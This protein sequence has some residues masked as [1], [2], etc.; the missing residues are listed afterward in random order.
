MI[1]IGI[2]GLKG[3]GKDTFAEMIF[4]T[5]GVPRIN[6]FKMAYADPLK[7]MTSGI[8]GI[9]LGHF[10]D[11]ALKETV[12]AEYGRTLRELLCSVADLVKKLHGVTYFRDAVVAKVN[13]LP[14]DAV[15][16]VTDVRYEFEADWIRSAH[17][18]IVQ[19]S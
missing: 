2:H 17:G 10:Y 19:I 12:Y 18:T 14:K 8:Y 9:P 3:S 16:I 11:E 1:I 5:S 13:K 6:F 7:K 15:V 4:R